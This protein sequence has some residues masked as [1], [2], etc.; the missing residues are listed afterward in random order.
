MIGFVLPIAARI[1]FGNRKRSATSAI[2]IAFVVVGG[3]A[4][5]W[6]H[7]DKKSAVRKAVMGVI[8]KVELEALQAQVDEAER[9][10]VI[11]EAANE[12][13]RADVAESAERAEAAAEEIERY[14]TDNKIDPT[15]R[16]TGNLYNRL[17]AK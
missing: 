7:F 5:T 11:I 14:E 8:A 12:T 9:R 10:A 6:H 16:V 13:L 2:V 1:F 17:R 3:A 4:V 15:G